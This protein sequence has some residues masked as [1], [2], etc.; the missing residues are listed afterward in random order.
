MKTNETG[1]SMVEMLGVLAIIGVLSIGGIAGYT[2]AMNRYRAN[3]ILDMANKYATIA[4][5]TLQSYGAR[6]S[7][8]TP[9]LS[10]IPT[11]DETSL[12]GTSNTVN[13]GTIQQATPLTS[14]GAALPTTAAS[15]GKASD[16]DRIGMLIEFGKDD[17]SICKAAASSLGYKEEANTSWG[18]N[19]HSYCNNTDKPTI[20]FV[21]KHS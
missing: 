18:A 10:K 14:E 15:N 12:N 2:T 19:G 9:D 6:T 8:K 7:G 16:Y 20:V 13:A 11:L 21:T 5:T 17:K 3:E 4:F 1:R